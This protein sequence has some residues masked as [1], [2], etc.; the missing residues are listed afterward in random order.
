MQIFFLFPNSPWANV[1]KVCMSE[2]VY[3]K[4][5]NLIKQIWKRERENI[6][7]IHIR[8]KTWKF[9]LHFPVSCSSTSTNTIFLSSHYHFRVARLFPCRN[10]RVSLS[11]VRMNDN[12]HNQR[13][14]CWCRKWWGEKEIRNYHHSS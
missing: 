1:E 9:S 5:S 3:A 7:F 4:I 8:G 2:R 12:F 10:I 11:W 6:Y 13:N 14:F